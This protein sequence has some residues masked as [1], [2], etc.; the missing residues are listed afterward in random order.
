MIHMAQSKGLPALMMEA[1]DAVDQAQ[2]EI[3]FSKIHR[4]FA[5]ELKD[6]TIA[7]WGIAFKPRT[8]DIREAPALILIDALLEA[9]VNLRVHDPEALGNLRSLYGDH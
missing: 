9:G 2:K 5:G 3:I 7:I 1:V 6:K 4:H 8:D